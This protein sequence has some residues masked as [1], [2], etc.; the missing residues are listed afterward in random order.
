MFLDMNSEVPIYQQIRNQIILGLAQGRL[1]DNDT[2]PSTRQLAADFGINFHT[3]NKAYDMLRQ[4]GVVRLNRKTGA[5]V[6]VDETPPDYLK[7]WREGARVWIAEAI[8]KGIDKSQLIRECE[9]I[10]SEFS[11]VEVAREGRD[12]ELEGRDAELEGHQAGKA[13][14]A[15]PSGVRAGS[16]DQVPSKG[17]E[18]GATS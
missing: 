8:V 15:N 6:S 13:R 7:R 12:A 16:K 2:L 18:G 4:E 11:G 9:S 17:H 1:R 3:V 5:V 10:V 14:E